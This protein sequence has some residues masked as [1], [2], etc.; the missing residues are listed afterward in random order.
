MERFI[1][2]L[3][4]RRWVTLTLTAIFALAG[5]VAWTRLP[6]DAFPDVTNVQ[7]MILTEAPGLS[8]V[9]V[10]QQ[11]TYPIEQQMG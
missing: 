3:L 8:T 4:A 7:V 6:I 11:I 1:N 5:W 2:I 10:E 9:D